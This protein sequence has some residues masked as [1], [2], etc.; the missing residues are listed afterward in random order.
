MKDNDNVS[1]RVYKKLRGLYHRK[2]LSYW[3]KTF[4]YFSSC[5]K[6]LDI[7]CGQGPF[8]DLFPKRS[9]GLDMNMKSLLQARQKSPV[10][11]G[12][13]VSLPFKDECF[14][15]ILCSHLIEHLEPYGAYNLLY[16]IGRILKRDGILILRGPLLYRQFFDDPTHI[17]PYPPNAV[18]AYYLNPTENHPSFERMHYNFVLVKLKW[19]YERLFY[20]SVEP[21]IDPSRYKM[22]F[23]LKT[24]SLALNRL[25]IHGLR[26]DGYTLVLKKI[27]V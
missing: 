17:R 13:A 11:R 21:M 15:G 9:V 23:V 26:K 8:L 22:S 2:V 24:I 3:D 14:D 10:V 6:I 20:P 4:D 7:G 5:N 27:S 25:G 19:R 1:I 12:D 16:E 18:L